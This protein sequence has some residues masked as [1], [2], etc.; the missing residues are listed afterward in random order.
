MGIGKS[1]SI[2]HTLLQVKFPQFFHSAEIWLVKMSTGG[3]PTFNQELCMGQVY[4]CIDVSQL[5]VKYDA[6]SGR[7][8]AAVGAGEELRRSVGAHS[9]C[10][11]A[12]SDGEF[13]PARHSSSIQRHAE[14]VRHAPPRTAGAL[15]SLQ[16]NIDKN[17]SYTVYP[18]FK[19]SPPFGRGALFKQHE[20][21]F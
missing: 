12:R 7:E 13:Q 9:G 20:F 1:V 19:K 3:N 11:R 6:F 17:R 15:E 2:F 5:K 8:I 10:H 18:S 4:S 16:P 14:H 21:K